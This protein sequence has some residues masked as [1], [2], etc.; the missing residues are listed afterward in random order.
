MKRR[1]DLDF[2]KGIGIILMVLGHSF[3][4]GNGEALK[5]WFYSF[6][7]PLFFLVSGILAREKEECR[8]VAY[9]VKHRA[10]GLLLPYYSWCSL[11]AVYLCVMGRKTLAYFIDLVRIIATFQG[12]SALW[13]LTCL[14]LAEILFAVTRKAYAFNRV[15]GWGLTVAIGLVGLL[16][17]NGNAVAMVVLRACTGMSFI[18][19]G[20]IG[21]KIFSDQRRHWMVFAALFI[22]H[23]ILAR[24]NGQLSVLGRVYG[25]GVLFYVNALVGTW[26]TI[27]TYHLLDA[28]CLEKVRKGV[29]WLGKNSIVLVC[30]S[31]F[32]IEFLRLADY[33]LFGGFLPRLGNAE[34]I[35]LC[36]TAILLEIPMIQASERF[37]WFAFGRKKPS[38]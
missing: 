29:A 27:Q 33:K 37:L 16:A 17:P 26:L 31:F 8:S 13:F 11:I 36:L 22:L 24:M 1:D 5:M 4:A 3:S 20:W 15:V 38:V 14:Y 10:R 28:K 12:L 30:T 34:G 2:A 19:L 21:A 35:V 18:W 7:M 6:H 32:A 23:F 25:N 9:T